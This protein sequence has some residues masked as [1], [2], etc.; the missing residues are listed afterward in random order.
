[1]AKRFTDTNKWRKPFIRSLQAPYKLLWFYILDDCDH[2]GI[3]IVDME[4]A[5]LRVG[6]EINKEEAINLFKDRI[7]IFDQGERWFIPDFIEFQYGDLNPANRAHNS[8]ISQL[9]KYELLKEYKALTSPLQGVKDKDKDKDKDKK[10]VR[11]KCL[12][13][14]SGITLAMVI[15]SFKKSDDIKMADP[16]YYYNTA[17]AWSDSKGEMRVDWIATIANFA[18]RDIKDGKLK[19]SKHRQVGGSNISRDELPKDYGKPSPTAVPMPQSVKDSISKIGKP[20][21]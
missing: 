3:W 10:G 2:A 13:R 7:V 5:Q 20:Q 18:R 1:M 9:R 8:V 16:S 11:G 21:E 6:Q 17:M 14:T 19:L 12:M 4:V 15:E